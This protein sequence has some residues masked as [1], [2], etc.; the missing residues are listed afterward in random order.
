MQS[1]IREIKNVAEWVS[2]MSIQTREQPRHYFDPEKLEQLVESIA[3]HGILEP[4]LVRPLRANE[5]EL[6]AGERRYRA[7][8]QL[9]LPEVPVVIRQLNEEEAIQLALIENLQR[10]DLNPIE[11]AEAYTRLQDEFGYTQEDLAKRVGK[12]RS[13][14]TNALRLLGL[15]DAVRSMVARGDL[16]AGHARTVLS[17]SDPEAMRTLAQTIIQE[18]LSVRQAEALAR[19]LKATEE[20][21]ARPKKPAFMDTANVRALNDELVRLLGTKVEIKD[22]GPKRGGSIEIAYSSYEEL[23]RILAVLRNSPPN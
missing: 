4:L 21:G 15:P 19:K 2:L 20:K 22:K 10:E 23:E 1:H 8:L 16:S 11:E 7:A 9:G 12:D 18:Q 3:R 17:L 14:V 13:T 6:V 5:Y